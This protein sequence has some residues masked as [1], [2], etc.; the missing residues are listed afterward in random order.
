MSPT[1][2]GLSCSSFSYILIEIGVSSP[3]AA[4]CTIAALPAS[5][6]CILLSHK[7]SRWLLHSLV[8]PLVA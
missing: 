5:V 1:M 7:A 4:I 6:W 8:M 2:C 3:P